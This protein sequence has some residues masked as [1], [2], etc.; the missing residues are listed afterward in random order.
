MYWLGIEDGQTGFYLYFCTGHSYRLAE[1]GKLSSGQAM[2]C[3][4]PWSWCISS[5]LGK[6]CDLSSYPSVV[7]AGLWGTTGGQ[8][9]S[10]TRMHIKSRIWIKTFVIRHT[11]PG[12]PLSGQEGRQPMRSNMITAQHAAPDGRILP[13]RYFG[14]EIVPCRFPHPPLP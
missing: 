9:L 10:N 6:S 4:D 14:P 11:N 7:L 12:D 3:C 8:R 2:I 5:S 13:G 1:P